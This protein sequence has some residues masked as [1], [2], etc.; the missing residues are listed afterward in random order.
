M[1]YKN[2]KK[3]NKRMGK[4]RAIKFWLILI[5]GNQ[6]RPKWTLQKTKSFQWYWEIWQKDRQTDN[7]INLLPVVEMMRKWEIHVNQ[8]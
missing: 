1:L 3:Q 6:K 5:F 2:A 4:L 7:L 8:H